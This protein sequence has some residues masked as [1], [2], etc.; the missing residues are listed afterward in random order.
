MASGDGAERAQDARVVLVTAPDRERG[1][2]IARALVQG[3][4]AA[5]VNVLPGLHSVYRWKGAVEESGEVLLIAKTTA[6]RLAEF[7]A[8]LARVHPYD[9]PECVAIAPSAVAPKYLAWLFAETDPR[10]LPR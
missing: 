4:T 2:E 6:A 8:A 3:G 10:S 1:L 7:E 5:C 9:V